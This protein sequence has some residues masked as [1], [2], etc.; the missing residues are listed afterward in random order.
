MRLPA[1]FAQDDRGAGAA[2][3]ALV[4]P[5]LLFLIFGTIN[6]FFIVYAAVNLHS[7]TEAAARY[8]SVTTAGGGAP[9]QTT[10]SAFGASHYVGPDVGATF[11][12]TAPTASTGGCSTATTGYHVAAT[13]AYRMYYGFGFQN[14]TLNA[15]ACFP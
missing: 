3:F 10:V 14:I 11:T 5:A 12:Y 13:G 1:A 4:L 9:T 6:L 7:A 8:A 2:E 15:N